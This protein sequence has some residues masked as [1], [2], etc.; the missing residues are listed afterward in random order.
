MKTSNSTNFFLF[1]T[2]FCFILGNEAKAQ[3]NLPRGSQKASVSQT[4]GLTNITIS[5]SRPSV[6]ERELWGELVPYGMNN[7]GFGTAKESPWRAGADEC[8]TIKFTDDISVEGKNLKAGIYGLFMVIHENNTVDIIFSNN[9]TA[10]GSY[11]YNPEDNALKVTVKSNEIP[12]VE[13]LTYSFNKVDATSATAS[14]EWGEKEIPF[15]IE[16]PVSKITLDNIKNELQGSAGFSNA[17]WT[18]AAQYA[19]NNNGD[20]TEALNWI[21]SSIEGRFFSQKNYNNLFI[22]SQILTKMGNNKE[23]FSVLEEASLLANMVQ[24]N[25]LGYQMLN[26]KEND[27]ALKFFIM[28]VKNNPKDP[29]VY[30]SLGECY[31]TIGDKK[32]AIKNLKKSLTL[33]PPPNVKANSENLL[34]ELGVKI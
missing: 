24:L 10:W 13:L 3:L 31:K 11:F 27:L 5:Y 25:A 19:L 16:V 12:S 32:N 4:V 33:N 21:N 34:A 23:A 9:S 7:L 8:T 26:Q 6:K 22:K 15:K 1:L 30:D 14:L 18:Q 28:N 29:N 20:L 17:S 2:L